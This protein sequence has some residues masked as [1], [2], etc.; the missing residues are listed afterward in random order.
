MGKDTIK[1]LD[2]MDPDKRLKKAVEDSI[3]IIAEHIEPGP[4]DCEKT[5]NELT[6]TLDNNEVKAALEGFDEKRARAMKIADQD[7]QD[8]TH[9]GKYDENEGRSSTSLKKDAAHVRRR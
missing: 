5:V 7:H 1:K 4:R 8:E 9:A 3:E 6:E 2:A